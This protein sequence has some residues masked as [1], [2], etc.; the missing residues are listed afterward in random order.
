MRLL[1]TKTYELKEFLENDVPDYVILSHRWGNEEVSFKEF[2]KGT[3]DNAGFRK[4]L[5]FCAFARSRVRDWVW[6]DTCCIDKRSSAEV[7]EAVN[8]MYNLYAGSRECYAYL[9]DAPALSHGRERVLQAMRQS[10]WFTRGWTLQELLAPS[11]VV[12]LTRHWE[13]IGSKW[14]LA[15]E[16]ST[17]TGIPPAIVTD[18]DKNNQQICA[19]Q[20]MSWAAS[21]RTTRPEDMAYSLLGIFGVNIP[22]LYGEG[23]LKSFRRLQ[24]Q[25]IADTDDE[26]IFAW[27][28]PPRNNFTFQTMLADSPKAFANGGEVFRIPPTNVLY[29]MRPHYAMTNKGLLYHGLRVKRLVK[30][31]YGRETPGMYLLALNCFDQT[32]PAWPVVLCKPSPDRV[33]FLRIHTEWTLAEIGSEYPEEYWEEVEM[34]PIY[35]Q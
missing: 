25:I 32:C 34:P 8:S 30:D 16:I 9:A 4:I 29:E 18:F 19:A 22:L 11:S 3:I 17:I 2:R 1:N 20:K 28:A 14:T 15:H 23:D 6:I 26:S 35:I 31:R 27:T 12:F 10:D 13:I 24:L 21:R 5:D 7:S 33:S